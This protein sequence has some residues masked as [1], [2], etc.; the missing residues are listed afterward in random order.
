MGNMDKYVIDGLFLTQRITG[1]QRYAYELVNELDRIV[2]KDFIEVLVPETTQNIPDYKNIKVVKYGKL[3]GIAWQQIDLFRYLHKN[4]KQ[5]IFLNNILPLFYRKGFITVHDIC[6]KANPQFYSSFRDKVSMLWHRLNYY[7]AVHSD[8]TILTVSDFSKGEIIKY[9]NV[10]RERINVIYC[11]WQHINKINQSSD[12]FEKYPMLN[13]NEYYFSMSTLGANK[14]FKWIL[15]AAKN[16]PEKTFTIAGGGKLKGAADAAGFADLPNI[17]FLGYVSDEDAKTLMANCKAFL[18]P[19]LYE[20][21]GI[22]PLEA[23]ACGCKQIFVS[24][25]PCMREIYGDFAGYLNQ[26]DYINSEIPQ[27]DEKEYNELLEKYSWEKSAQKLYE[28]IY[29]QG[30][31]I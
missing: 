22:P 26:N 31:N 10:P 21:F 4:K 11:G 27:L 2:E 15:Y 24:D 7:A 23:V 17:H 18:F 20:G 28:Y 14:N 12:T 16:N 25:T 9:Y 8:I 30:A 6:Y 1:T 5:G 3:K 29:K 13:P 19:T